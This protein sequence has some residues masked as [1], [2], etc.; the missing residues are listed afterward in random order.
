MDADG[1]ERTGGPLP[2]QTQQVVARPRLAAQAP[3]QDFPCTRD[4]LRCAN[5]RSYQAEMR[6]CCR[7]HL[8][9]MIRDT[10]GLLVEYKVTFFADY[11]T[12]LGA[13][14]N[15]LTTWA[16]YP[17]LPQ[18]NRPSEPLAPGIIPHD[19]DADFGALWSDWS[20]LM[21]V[22]AGLERLGYAVRVN[23][24]AAKLKIRLSEKNHTNLDIFCWRSRSD[25]SFSRPMYISVDHFKG[26]DIPKDKLFQLTTVQWEGMSLPAPAD[27]EAFCAFRYG[28]NWRT[29]IPANHDGV[30]R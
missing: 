12:L 5:A 24:P 7:D 9:T 18:Q 14:R 2:V 19:K 3:A 20:K 30:R 10:V 22:R 17:W 25:G 21:R 27:P 13:V 4:T 23:P 28:E 29:P 6:S 15:P 11:G 26:R 1:E 16:D 8:V